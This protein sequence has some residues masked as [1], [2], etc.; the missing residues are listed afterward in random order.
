MDRPRSGGYRRSLRCWHRFY[1]PQ[2]SMKYPEPLAASSS[3]P[4]L[5]CTGRVRLTK[6]RDAGL[7]TW[8][9]N[10]CS[11]QPGRQWYPTGRGFPLIGTPQRVSSLDRPNARWLGHSDSRPSDG[12]SEMAERY[13]SDP[14]WTEQE[15]TR[16]RYNR[17][18]FI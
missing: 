9:C 2:A 1:R 8:R 3:H 4:C 7:W 12:Q 10:E 5:Y 18:F 17:Q 11:R 15:R 16:H 6:D 14:F 13:R